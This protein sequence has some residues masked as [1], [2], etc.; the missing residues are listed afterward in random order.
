MA[1]MNIGG[2]T[3]PVN[4]GGTAPVVPKRPQLDLSQEGLAN[5]M[6]EQ[7]ILQI[8]QGGTP[9]LADVLAKCADPNPTE[10]L[11]DGT[12]VEVTRPGGSGPTCD[13]AEL[14]AKKVQAQTG[15]RFD[16]LN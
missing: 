2:A 3:N 11:P 7:A 4:A 12:V 14:A 16:V 1:E 5:T 15:Y 13:A 8:S 9:K 10:T 6:A